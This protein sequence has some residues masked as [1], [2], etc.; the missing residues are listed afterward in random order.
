MNARV[1]KDIRELFPAWAGA[2]GLALVAGLLFR[3]D[4]NLGS[5]GLPIYWLGLVGLG[6]SLFGLELSQRTIGLILIQPVRRR[7]IWV[8]KSVVGAGCFLLAGL[9][10]FVTGWSRQGLLSDPEGRTMFIAMSILMPMAAMGGGLGFTL[11]LRHVHGAFWL[12]LLFP[13]LLLTA[14]LILSRFAPALPVQHVI[15]FGLLATYS[16]AGY[17]VGMVRFLR[18]EWADGTDQE[19]SLNLE[20]WLFLFRMKSS[21]GWKALWKKEILLHQVNWALAILLGIFLGASVFL[22]DRVRSF[23]LDLLVHFFLLLVFVVFPLLL[24]ATAIAEE[25]KLGTL[26]WHQALPF[27]RGKQ[28]FAKLAVVMGAG[29][30]VSGIGFF[31][32]FVLAREE[33]LRGFLFLASLSLPF[34]VTGFWASSVARNLL[35]AL[36]IAAGFLLLGALLFLAAVYLIGSAP[37]VPPSPLLGLIWIPLCLAAALY[38]SFYNFREGALNMRYNLV[39]LAACYLASVAITTALYHRV[40]EYFGPAMQSAARPENPP[41]VKPKIVSNWNITVVLGPDGTLW[42][43]P[44]YP[45]PNTPFETGWLALDLG[46]EQARPARSRENRPQSP[47]ARASGNRHEL[48]AGRRRRQSFSG[49]EKGSYALGL[50]PERARA[51]GNRGPRQGGEPAPDR[52][53]TLDCHCRSP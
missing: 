29:I 18:M 7:N 2:A 15:L 33:S 52:R 9:I 31:S 28:W 25:R 21:S 53:P 3:W 47:T 8:E 5:V 37:P 46:H 16:I 48:A 19:K 42:Q 17:L 44:E 35:H 4:S 51:I 11:L 30:L 14:M 41:L 12:A 49:T 26:G 23:D 6:V 50:G 36:A 38:L 39:L 1:M 27:S 40:W 32:L 24:G 22:Q 34:A 45:Q 20:S 43:S 13:G 10:F